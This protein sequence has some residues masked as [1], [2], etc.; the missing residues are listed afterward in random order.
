MR[1]SRN[2]AAPVLVRIASTGYAVPGT[3]L[4]VGLLVPLATLDNVI[5]DVM[6]ASF[7]VSTGLILTGSGAA[8]VLAYV[9][10]F[11]AISAGSIEA[12]LAKVSPH[13]DMAARS[14]GSRPAKIL[15][16]IHLPLIA[17]AIFA[18]AALVFVDVMREPPGS[19]SPLPS[20]KASTSSI[21]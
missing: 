18:A 17:P 2:P 3:V 12:G 21:E 6:R 9:L 7:G 19:E 11:L 4:A 20:H 5:A 16:T 13:L 15:A 8:L 10:R 1:L 14:L